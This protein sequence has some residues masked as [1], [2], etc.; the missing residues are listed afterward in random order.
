MILDATTGLP[1]LSLQKAGLEKGALSLN[2]SNIIE[3]TSGAAFVAMDMLGKEIT[4]IKDP[5]TDQ[6][7]ATKITT[8]SSSVLCGITCTGSTPADLIH[9]VVNSTSRYIDLT[10]RSS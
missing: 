10:I 1:R 4:G 6:S 2:A 8:I 9:G 3:A 7:A 5:T